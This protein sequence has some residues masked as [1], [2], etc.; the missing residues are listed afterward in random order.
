MIEEVRLSVR[1]CGWIITPVSSGRS[2]SYSAVPADCT[3]MVSMSFWRWAPYSQHLRTTNNHG[4]Q[5]GRVHP[6]RAIA[7]PEMFL[8]FHCGG[9]AAQ[10][11][12]SP[13]RARG[14]PFASSLDTNS[15]GRMHCQHGI[16]YISSIP[17]SFCHSGLA[18]P[19]Q[20]L[21]DAINHHLSPAQCLPKTLFEL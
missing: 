8:H 13:I 9:S 21:T 4:R 5:G 10:H 16:G 11:I 15:I 3:E 7:T 17:A 20:L 14:L 1:R 12:L 18:N 2:G 6:K 19:N